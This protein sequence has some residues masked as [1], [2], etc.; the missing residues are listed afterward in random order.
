MRLTWRHRLLPYATEVYGL[1]RR[2]A[3]MVR[4]EPTVGL[5]KLLRAC[6][7]PTSV[8]CGWGQYDAAQLVAGY[9]RDELRRRRLHRADGPS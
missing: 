7:Q 8:N 6:D 4:N 5:Q 2:I 3:A 1:H 9:A